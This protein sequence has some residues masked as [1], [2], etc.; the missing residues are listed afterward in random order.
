MPYEVKIYGD[1]SE[2]SGPNAFTLQDLQEQLKGYNNEESLLVRVKTNGGIV[3]E[4]FSIYNELRRFAKDKGIKIIT[5]LDGLVASIGTVIFLAG[6]R[7]IVNPYIR[8]F[9][10]NAYGDANPE[11]IN[12][13]NHQIAKFYAE[14]TLM[15]IDEAKILMEKETFISPEEALKMKFGTEIEE[16]QRPSFMMRFT[17]EDKNTKNIAMDKKNKER[18]LLNKILDL[19]K[20]N[21]IKNKIIFDANNEELEFPELAEEDVIIEG[22]KANYKGQPANGEIIVADGNTYVFDNGILKAIKKKIDEEVGA[23][24]RDLE[25]KLCQSIAEVQELKSK[26]DVVNSEKNK[27]K[28][29]LNQKNMIIDKIKA[30]ESE[31]I[32]EDKKNKP[33][34]PNKDKSILSNID[35]SKIK[36]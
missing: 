14:N 12:Y 27:I 1:I 36:I 29:E 10:H 13:V 16:I 35:L 9:I 8:P 19:I 32:I 24:K 22:V 34:E 28:N 2:Q 18:S 5:R 20:R 7:R 26:L 3:D 23:E 31:F 6:D 21:D 25:E 4:G 33:D 11:D 30:L 15:T 17:S